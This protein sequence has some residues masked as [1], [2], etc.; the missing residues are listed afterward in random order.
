MQL[1]SRNGK[2]YSGVWAW[3]QIKAPIMKTKIH[4]FKE[5]ER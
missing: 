3:L 5:S 4:S 1:F 2:C